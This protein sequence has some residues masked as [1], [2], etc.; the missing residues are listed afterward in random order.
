MSDAERS[1]DDSTPETDGSETPKKPYKK[2]DFLHER[3][4]ETM[5]L[6]CGKVSITQSQCRFVRKNS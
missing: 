5:A 6:A 4:F 2:P 1:H 3:V